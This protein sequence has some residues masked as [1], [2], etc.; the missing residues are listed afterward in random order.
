MDL[1]GP[2]YEKRLNIYDSTQKPD[3]FLNW[4]QIF[5]SKE[6]AK[7]LEREC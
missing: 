1:K 5:D 4:K 3:F 2:G 6:N 7:F